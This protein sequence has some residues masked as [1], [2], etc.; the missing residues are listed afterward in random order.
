MNKMLG[1]ALLVAGV[2]L[3]VIGFNESRSTASEISK[4]FNNSP[5]NRSLWFMVG[6]GVSA[7]LGLYLTMAKSRS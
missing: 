3:L 5:T 7:A 2:V 4:L 1:I 6:G